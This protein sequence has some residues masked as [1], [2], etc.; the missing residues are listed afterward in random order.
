MAPGPV[1][2]GSLCSSAVGHNLWGLH[3]QVPNLQERL[4]AVFGNTLGIDHHGVGLVIAGGAANAWAHGRWLSSSQDID[5]FLV[6]PDAA[7]VYPRLLALL[8]QLQGPF[9]WQQSG[10]WYSN[11]RLQTDTELGSVDIILRIFESPQDVLRSFD[12]DAS[13][14]VCM[15]AGILTTCAGSTPMFAIILSPSSRVTLNVALSTCAHTALQRHFALHQ[16]AG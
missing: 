10:A 11:C 16:V 14:F 2:T 13:K 5:V 15:G 6:G 9:V 8:Q 7:S 4:Q 12:L 3:V 1:D